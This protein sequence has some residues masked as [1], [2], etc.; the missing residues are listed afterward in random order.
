M[1]ECQTPGMCAP[2]GGCQPEEVPPPQT[3]G[4]K[5]PA[6]GKGNAPWAAVCGNVMCGN[7]GQ[8]T[9]T[10][11]VVPEQPDPLPTMTMIESFNKAMELQTP[12][13]LIAG[14]DRLQ[15]ERM[16]TNGQL[17]RPMSEFPK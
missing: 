14:L 7:G 1:M 9:V 17:N 6:C 4:W 3:I 11:G 10:A 12:P 5:C 2:F 8:W 15:K 16:V 13:E